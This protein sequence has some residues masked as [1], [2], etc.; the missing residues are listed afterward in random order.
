MPGSPKNNATGFEPPPGSSTEMSF[1]KMICFGW[2][3]P[4]FLYTIGRIL[5]NSKESKMQE[6]AKKKQGEFGEIPFDREALLVLYNQTEAR[7]RSHREI[8]WQQVRHFSWLIAII[9]TASGYI[10]AKSVEFESIVWILPFLWILSWYIGHIAAKIIRQER[11]EFL[12]AVMVTRKVEK[13]LGLH[14]PVEDQELQ[15]QKGFSGYLFR[16]THVD[17][18]NRAEK[19]WSERCGKVGAE[20]AWVERRMKEES[21]PFDRYRVLFYGYEIV[22]IFLLA[23][24]IYFLWSRFRFYLPPFIK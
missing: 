13:A 2:I 17:V 20:Q 10:W 24:S 12:R 1:L 9:V 6:D 5:G 7:I 18:F 23:Y 22:S 14:K 3:I 21:A 11:E 8:L 15:R 4:I 19:L 16:F